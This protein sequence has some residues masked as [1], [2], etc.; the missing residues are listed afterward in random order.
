MQKSFLLRRLILLTLFCLLACAST[1][2]Q[3][4]PAAWAAGTHYSVNDRASYNGA[5]YKCL[6]AHTAI[7]SWEPPN[8]PALWQAE[9]GGATTAGDA[10]FADDFEPARGWTT[11]AGGA[12]TAT[13]G[14][15]QRGAP[16]ASRVKGA[17]Q[18][19][20]HGGA[21]AL[22]T[23]LAAGNDVSGGATSIRSPAIVL[24]SGASGLTLT[25]WFS[26]A[27]DIRGNAADY[28]S[29]KILGDSAQSATTILGR[30]RNRNAAWQKQTVNLDRFAG[31]TIRVEFEAKDGEIDNTLEAEVD[32]VEIKQTAVAGG[33]FPSRV[34]APYVDTLLYPAF[35]L[36]QTAASTGV[37]YFTLAFITNGANRC[38]ASWGG[39]IALS[40]NYMLADINNLRAAG[41]NVI[42]SF[43]GAN[44]TEL[45]QSCQTV[46]ALAVQYRAVIE[47]YNSTSLDFD[48]EGGAILDAAANDRRAKAIAVLQSEAAAENRILNVSFTLPVLPTGLEQSGVSLLRNAVANNVNV[49]IVNIMAMDYGAVADPNRMGQN[50]VD[51][52]NATFAQ[53]QPVFSNRAPSDVRRMIGITPMIGLNDV[54]PE[55]FTL[56]DAQVLLTYANANNAGR[57]A[58]WSATRDKPC[59][60]APQVAA[61]CSGVAQTPF[62][63]A[64][65]FK[66]FTQP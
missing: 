2:A 43:G 46:D 59:A 48:I 55:V 42:M 21:N 4:E 44:G 54:S 36:A 16:E 41:G 22:A 31:Q 11:N 47:K 18:I 49:S 37:K 15:W 6:Q 13:S 61:D 63:F 39:V 35:P 9:T 28:F 50:A 64:N 20:A 12:D 19:A 27:H 25:F 58:M 56:S 17:K 8:A 5:N 60:G 32:D 3:S 65:A 57:I 14:A 34:F 38:Q 7:Q 51:A 40:E 53:I 29:V 33:A 24:P 1:K 66:S 62:A 23:G 45:A 26:F 30:R 10:I 52:A